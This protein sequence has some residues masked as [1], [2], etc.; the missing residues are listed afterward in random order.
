MIHSIRSIDDRHSGRG[1]LVEMR[2]RTP[3]RYFESANGP[4]A[5]PIDPTLPFACKRR[6]PGGAGV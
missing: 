2:R 1:A 3:K 5:H 6:A 4:R